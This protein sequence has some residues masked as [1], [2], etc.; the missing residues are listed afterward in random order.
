MKTN[1]IMIMIQQLGKILCAQRR[2]NGWIFV[3]LV[4][5]MCTIWFL[6]D[7]LWVDQRSY[8]APLG[9]DT[10]NCWRFLLGV[11]PEGTP[12]YVEPTGEADFATDIQILMDRM[13][14]E[15]EIEEVCLCFW[16]MPYSP[17]N[18]WTS[19]CRA[20]LDTADIQ[21]E[22]FHSLRITPT[23][24]D[25]F[26]I[27]DAAGQSVTA[28]VSDGRLVFVLSQALAD[29]LIPNEQ[30]V[31]KS[32]S[33]SKSLDEVYPV[34]AVLP[35]FRTI[36]F[37][38]EES[39]SFVILTP[40]LL[41]AYGNSYGNSSYQ[42]AQLCVRMKK[43][44]TEAEMTAFLERTADRM[45]YNNKFVQG[46]KSME[47]IRIE[48][49]KSWFDRRNQQMGVILFVMIN[50]FFG[51]VGTFWLRTERRR[52]EIG[53]RLAMG[54]SHRQIGLLVLLEGLILLGLTLPFLL[55]F[56]LNMAKADLLETYRESLSLFRF[57]STMGLAYLLLA[58][59]IA[60]GVWYPMRKAIQLPPAEALRYE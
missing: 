53:L 40:D 50:V 8:R 21:L 33:V 43:Q 6:V 10:E 5:A 48:K 13:R 49:M 12:N 29:H 28:Q 19:L 24:F 56:A 26:R 60:L 7:K 1:T 39:C 9:Y 15:S 58:L 47:E 55:L 52:G 14:Q 51:I 16:S 17:G 31:G 18:T 36:D 45:Q 20:D 30:A 27:R 57:A 46:A 38:P 25:L 44:M 4:I 32:I 41:N 2:T 23:Y 42:L 37:E 54:S 35:H 22:S 3:E 11:I 34:A 59:L